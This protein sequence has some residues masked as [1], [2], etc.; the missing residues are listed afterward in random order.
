MELKTKKN[1]WRIHHWLWLWFSPILHH[2]HRRIKRVRKTWLIFWASRCHRRVLLRQTSA[3]CLRTHPFWKTK[4]KS[5]RAAMSC[6]GRRLKVNRNSTHKCPLFRRLNSN[7][8]TFLRRGRRLLVIIATHILPPRVQVYERRRITTL[9]LL[10]LVRVRVWTSIFLRIDFL[11]ILMCLE[12][13]EQPARRGLLGRVW[14]GSEMSEKKT[15]F[16]FD[17]L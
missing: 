2:H 6:H 13:W 5:R 15:P 4:H 17:L 11:K 10:V 14:S 9:V 16:N 8:T 7:R 12:T 3:K 1:L